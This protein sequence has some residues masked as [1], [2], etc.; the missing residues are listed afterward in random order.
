VQDVDI[1]IGKLLNVDTALEVA[2]TSILLMGGDGIMADFGVMRHMRNMIVVSI[3]EGTNR[4][5]H[6]LIIAR[7]ITGSEQAFK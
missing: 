1:S 2:T 4:H 3:Y 7:A 5:I 6:P